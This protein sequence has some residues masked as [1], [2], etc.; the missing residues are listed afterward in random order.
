MV[1][2]MIIDADRVR[3]WFWSANLGGGTSCGSGVFWSVGV[4]SM[5]RFGC[6]WLEVWFWWSNRLDSKNPGLGSRKP[7]KPGP[8]GGVGV[9][10]GL[11][12]F[13]DFIGP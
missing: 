10:C 9:G 6:L 2:T 13:D 3:W 5:L 4:E 8:L 12:R 11:L 1:S 7:Q